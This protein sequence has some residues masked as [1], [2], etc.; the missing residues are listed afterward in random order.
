MKPIMINTCDAWQSYASFSFVGVYT[1][2][3]A[4]KKEIKRLI[5][6][7]IIEME[8]EMTIHE[9]NFYDVKTLQNQI[10]YINFNEIELNISEL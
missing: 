4:F 8:D 1:N 2:L 7:N 5:H 10:K 3:R 6:N 9:L